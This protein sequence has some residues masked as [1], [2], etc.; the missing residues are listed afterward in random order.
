MSRHDKAIARLIAV[1]TPADFPWSDLVSLLKRLGYRLLKNSGSRRK[2]YHQ[3]KDALII[4][5][6][7]HPSSNVDRGCVVAV[8]EHL[9]EHGFIQ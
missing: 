8:V 7:P 9:R 3:G 5:H 1:P 6:E 2:F 4:C